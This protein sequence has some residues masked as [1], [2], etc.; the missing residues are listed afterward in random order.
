MSALLSF[1]ITM[2]VAVVVFLVVVVIDMVGVT[3]TPLKVPGS[4][5]TQGYSTLISKEE[6]LRAETGHNGID[7]DHYLALQE[8]SGFMKEINSSYPNAEVMIYGKSYEGRDLMAVKFYR[9][10]CNPTIFVEAGIHAREWIAS[11]VTFKI[12]NTI[13]RNSS[14][15]E[16]MSKLLDLYNWVFVP[17]VNPD[18]YDFSRHENRYWRKN[19][20]VVTKNCTGVDLNRNFDINWGTVD[21]SD[22]PC[23]DIYCGKAPFSEPETQSLK[24][25][26]QAS[27]PLI[28]Y[29]SLHA[30]AQLII[31]PYSY[32]KATP[33]D[34]E[35]LMKPVGVQRIGS[36]KYLALNTRM[37][38]KCGPLT[39]TRGASAFQPVR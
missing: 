32:T 23:S 14:Q 31:C 20:R 6:V 15:D 12:I 24:T 27:W 22:D 17:L 35:E 36:R 1:V 9:N 3:G 30:Y 10:S 5:T 11:A 7:I 16:E 38:L 18:G 2:A 33:E 28:G 25:F 19:K 34:F 37:P 13:A 4:N 39:M 26:I 8:Y 21:A 29:I